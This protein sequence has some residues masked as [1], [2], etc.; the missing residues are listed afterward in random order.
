MSCDPIGGRAT[1]LLP[2]SEPADIYLEVA[3]YVLDRLER[4]AANME[5]NAQEAARQWVGMMDRDLV[6]HATM[7]T[8]YGV[9][10]RTIY[11]QIL[12]KKG[13]FLKDP[14]KCCRYLAKVLVESI[15]EVAVEAAKI[16]NWLRDLAQAIA[17]ANR[18]M[19]WTSPTGF[20]V[21]HERRKPKA[22]R[23]T[24]KDRTFLL[25]HYD[26]KRKID[27]RKQ[28]DGIVA[29]FVHSLDAAHMMRTIN[30]LVAAG[31]HHFA[32]VHDSYGVHACDVDILNRV[33]REEFVR[34]YSEPVLQ[35][36]LDEQRKAH[37][38]ID[39][40]DLPQL[41]SLDIRQVLTSQY[42]FA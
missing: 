38:D 27:V 31:I 8:P 21:V 18:G 32:I 40:P 1:N 42:F 36:F 14:K 37:P 3:N 13:A 30:C 33:L 10:E 35:I 16:M 41:G 4:D 22:V 7:T 2:C 9:T 23:V 5:G 26:K 17:K 6:K 12:K 29:H 15:P 11:K 20:V 19:V 34:I 25:Y 28:A 39:L 24:T